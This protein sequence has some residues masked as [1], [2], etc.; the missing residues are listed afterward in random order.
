MLT[1]LYSGVD[2]SE[3]QRVRRNDQRAL[4]GRIDPQ[5]VI[6]AFLRGRRV[7]NTGMGQLVQSQAFT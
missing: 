5:A 3:R 7:R 4:Q 1:P 6:L 2:G